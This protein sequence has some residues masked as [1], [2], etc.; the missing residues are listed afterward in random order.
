MLVR[1]GSPEEMAASG[2]ISEDACVV[3]SP[4]GMSPYATGGGGVT[5]ERKVAV[6]YLVRLLV[7]DGAAELGDGRCVVS[8]AFQQAPS[9]RVDDLV[10]R[11]ARPGE[12]EPSLVL[13][14]A[15]RRSPRLVVSDESTRR[16]FG[17]FV[18]AVIDAPP[19]GPEHRLGLVVA[20]PQQKVAQLGTLAA[21]A[22]VQ[23]DAPGFFELIRTPGNFSAKVCGR[24]VQIEKLVRH[25]L[26]DLF[27]AEVD[28]ALV[29]Q[30]TW[31][32]LS[33]LNVLMPQ[34]ESPD[35]ADWSAVLNS[36]VV[37]ARGFDLAGASR[38]RDRLVALAS[39]YS[40]RAARVDRTLLQGDAH[41]VLDVAARRH[42]RGWRALD[43]LHDR[44]LASVRDEIT[45][46]DSTRRLR[47]DR[48]VAAAELF[49]AFADAAAVVVTGESGVGKSALAVR[50]LARA[51][52]ADPNAVRAVCVNLR[53]LPDRT[54][55]LENEL[56]CPLAELL[57][58]LRAAQR[59]LVVDGADAAGEGWGDV[60][61]YL[62]DAARECDVKVIAVCAGDTKELVGSMLTEQV[63]A[64]VA[65]HLVP[66]LTDAE[67]V[68]V[69]E[70]FPELTDLCA[71]SRA[72]EVLRRL[73]VIDLLVRGRVSGVPLTD[74][75]AMSEVW[76]GFVRRWGASDRGSP[77]ARELVLLSLAKC[78]LTGGSRLD[79]LEG[80]DSAA[81][82]GLCAD[83]LLR[84]SPKDSIVT[85]PEF[86]HDEVR[87][88]AV[89]RLLVTDDGPGPRLLRAGAPRWS[90]A[91][92]RLACQVW[93]AQP[94]TETLP[95]RGRFAALRESFDRLV[96]AGHDTRWGDVPGEA[97]LSL[98]DPDAVL[99]DA[100]PDLRAKED[101]GLRRLARLVD[102]RL[103][104][105]NRVLN[106][107]AVEPIISLLLEDDVPWE[108][109]DYAYRLL[110]DWLR[111]HIVS[112][113]P[114]G[115]S[116]RIRLRERLVESC[117]A[118]D[119]RLAAQREAE[120]AARAARSPEEVDEERRAAERHQGLV[121]A[122][123]R[124][125]WQ[126]RPDLP[127]EITDETMLELLALLGPDLGSDG[128]TILRRVARDAPWTLAPAVERR[129]TGRALAQYGHR[130]LAQLTEAYYLDA[131]ADHSDDLHFGVRPHDVRALGLGRLFAWDHGPFRALF[132]TDFRDGVAVLNRLLNHAARI[133]ARTMAYHRLMAPPLD[134][135]AVVPYETDLTITGENRRYIG[136]GQVWLWYRGMGTGPYPCMTALQALEREC[137]RQIKTGTPIGTVLSILLDGCESLAMVGL[138]AG[139]LV[140]HL[141]VANRLLDRYLA[142]PFIWELEFSRAVGE[143]AG[144]APPSDGLVAPERRD[145]T[146]RQAAA[147]MVLEADDERAIELRAVGETLVANK[148][149]AI[150]STHND[151][152]VEGAEEDDAVEHDLAN[153]RAWACCLDRSTY[154]FHEGPDHVY[155]T[156]TPPE[157]VTATLQPERDDLR[158]A[159]DDSRLLNRY[160]GS[161][162]RGRAA[163]FTR[164]ELS[165]DIVVAQQLLE[166][167]PSVSAQL[168]WNTPALVAAAALDAHVL[169]GF[170][171]PD[172]VI[173]FATNTVL[174][175]GEGEHRP[176]DIE[177]ETSYF[178]QGADRS[179]ARAVPRL[180]LPAAAQLRA[181]IDDTSG[182][183]TLDRATAAA[184]CLARASTYEV[185]LHLARG[186]DHLWEA[187]CTEATNCHHETGIHLATEIMRDCV[188]S[189]PDP[190]SGRRREYSLDDPVIESLA[191]TPSRSIRVSRL[192]SAIRTL[193]P[194]ATADICVSTR[195]RAL[196]ITLLDAQRRTLLSHQPDDMDPRGTHT[197]V[198]A[199]S[200]LTL[201]AHGNDE[202]VYAHI[203]AYADN[204]VLLDKLLRA[205]SAA[206]E[207]TSDLAETARRIWPN[208]IRR[209][210]APNESDRTPFDGS[211]DGDLALAAL[212]PNPATEVTSYLYRELH[213]EPITWWDPLAF[214]PEI[215]AWLHI[216][217]GS[218]ICV[219]E[220]VM[221]L[222]VLAPENQANVGIPWVAKLVINNPDRIANR[223]FTLTDWLIEICSAAAH[224]GHA[225]TWQRIVDNLTVA[226][227]RRLAHYS[228]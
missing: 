177:S 164:D 13:A 174:R 159:E 31:E 104:D 126:E 132:R 2:E 84:S 87:R 6:L 196:L 41:E 162:E 1:E 193:T 140:R 24:L 46:S 3:G 99:R 93:L 11:A 103:R 25:A 197:L 198:G 212:L 179:A 72:R 155:V 8:V 53:H 56:G 226:G 81:L 79:F 76:E 144:M 124:R 28:A 176:L 85:G 100:W 38:L 15:V 70:A 118:A 217:T 172:D 145:W 169:Q 151:T 207:E 47:L 86:A 105:A 96:E 9:F 168:R 150:E 17:D 57:G 131:D 183:S 42:Q 55:R 94:D 33:R 211:L 14:L 148:R 21:H 51:G 59:L 80:I 184:I 112:D 89:A 50:S 128:E 67:L 190:T 166:N 7:G 34:L 127:Y 157:E 181:I 75:D 222:S 156:S 40:P 130:L 111:A 173:A 71:N 30:R 101:A 123:G 170:E 202:A 185:P 48:T 146:F 188:L 219:D 210:L 4:V 220:L 138:T 149:R 83:G 199:R 213:D 54:L 209:V 161:R 215:D 214:R 16:L 92:A 106:T 12:A 20:G 35:E 78:E 32:L 221:F 125:R 223:T 115:Q 18:R 49:A 195:A 153:T 44:A 23:M 165:A 178:E 186:L 109:G 135:H 225:P 64:R 95:L 208:I 37:V 122:F 158:R 147:F 68:Q 139:I 152:P 113:T 26:E 117:A 141:E 163:E 91:A 73:V 77:D 36:L 218:A 88:Y 120:A 60:F 189:D 194:A 228:D 171:L 102:Q 63:G 227:D 203:D 82:A 142:E 114:A 154:Q 29:E 192:D 205:L 27:R 45:A 58:E 43:H 204:P 224:T 201:S 121:S 119:R 129:L 61:R 97:L 74:A 182:R 62:V 22:A 216:A 66:P 116:V 137:D 187:P 206:A 191:H 65:E 69:A 160:L 175:I 133:R 52:V 90:L 200:L 180:L 110:R 5:F 143:M 98:A 136:D 134:D 39:E 107:I 19:D 10:V 108:T 167:P